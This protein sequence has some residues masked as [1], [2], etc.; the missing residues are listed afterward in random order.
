MKRF[1]YVMFVFVLMFSV[2]NAETDITYKSWG[3]ERTH[4]KEF[5]DALDE[6]AK[7]R[8]I[9]VAVI[10]T[11][12]YTGHEVFNNRLKPSNYN[13]NDVNGGHGTHVAGIV[14]DLTQGTNVKIIPL[15]MNAIATARPGED[16]VCVAIEEAIAQNVDII[17][18]S[19]SWWWNYDDEGKKDGTWVS[20][21]EGIK[22]IEENLYKKMKEA[23][24]NGIMF[25]VSTGNQSTCLDLIGVLNSKKYDVLD[26]LVFVGS[27]SNGTLDVTGGGTGVQ[28]NNDE[29]LSGSN[30]GKIMDVIAP[31]LNILSSVVPG[32]STVQRFVDMKFSLFP[33]SVSE[34]GYDNDTLEAYAKDSVNAYAIETGTSMAAPHVTSILALYKQAYPDLASEQLIYL[35]EKCV[36]KIDDTMTYGGIGVPNMS[37]ALCSDSKLH[38]FDSSGKCQKC[39]EATL[40]CIKTETMHI[41]VWPNDSSKKI[42]VEGHYFKNGK[43][44]ECSYQMGREYSNS[45]PDVTSDH[46][47]YRDISYMVEKGIVK[48]AYNP[49]VG[50]ECLYPNNN[51]TAEAFISLV[52]R[53]LGYDGKEINDDSL[54]MP[55]GINDRWSKGEWKYLMQKLGNNAKI[56]I[57]KVLASDSISGSDAEIMQNYKSDITRERAA[58]LMGLFVNSTYKNNVLEFEDWDEVNSQYEDNLKVLVSSELLRGSKVNGKLCVRPGHTITRAEAVTLISRLYALK[59]AGLLK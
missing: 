52:S 13:N 53:V 39:G 36:D 54:Y 44:R 26:D 7:S 1:F 12:V 49:D 6:E 23:V 46:W 17:N 57:Q 10:D 55:N 56:E 50:K 24:D 18:L 33:N 20:D 47:G 58:Y 11:G 42:K 28:V 2:V 5:V 34:L 25:V 8:E 59:E 30:Y 48:G 9:V 29:I 32:D 15:S 38:N 43:C 14:A 37:K 27:L 31:G 45:F 3:A 4:V 16:V 19:Q 41:Y 40:K 51:I 35:L 21:E 22:E